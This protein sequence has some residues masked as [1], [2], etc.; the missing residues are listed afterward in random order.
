MPEYAATIILNQAISKLDTLAVISLAVDRP[1]ENAKQGRPL[2]PLVEGAWVE[3]ELPKLGEPPPLAIDV[4]STVGTD[5]ARFE[6]LR[7]VA[8][9]RRQ[10][11]WDV[12]PDFGPSDDD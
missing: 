10:T 12:R 8:T 6:A 11:A 3:V 2:I 7:L 5:H 4:Y 9:L 1:V